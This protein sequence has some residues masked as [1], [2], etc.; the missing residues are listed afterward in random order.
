MSSS[1]IHKH[2]VSGTVLGLLA[3]GVAIATAC[4]LSQL[5]GLEV[6]GG[7]WTA[8]APLIALYEAGGMAGV[9]G[10]FWATTGLLVLLTH[11]EFALAARS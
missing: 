7:T 11:R 6:D 4:L 9:A 3:A 2:Q 5:A 1:G 10:L 8:P